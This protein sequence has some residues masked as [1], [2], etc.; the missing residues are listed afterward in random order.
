MASAHVTLL[1]LIT[2]AAYTRQFCKFR[3]SHSEQFLIGEKIN[4]ISCSET[5]TTNAKD[6]IV[7][8]KLLF[9]FHEVAC[10]YFKVWWTKSQ[11]SQ[12][13]SELCVPKIIKSADI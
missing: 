12:M 6:L 5:V 7:E 10:L 9:G 8:K 11:T 1:D 4:P 2:I 3:E 13:S